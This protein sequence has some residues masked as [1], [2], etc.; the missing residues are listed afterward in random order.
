MFKIG[1]TKRRKLYSR[2]S[3]PQTPLARPLFSV[4]SE[5]VIPAVLNS[6]RRLIKKSVVVRKKFEKSDKR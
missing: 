4:V 6:P 1:S 5:V 3:A 2:L